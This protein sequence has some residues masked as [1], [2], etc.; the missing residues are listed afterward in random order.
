[1][2]LLYKLYYM[3]YYLYKKTRSTLVE[4]QWNT[5]TPHA[6][7]RGETLASRKILPRR[8]PSHL[9]LLSRFTARVGRLMVA[10]QQVKGKHNNKYIYVGFKPN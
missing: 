10:T 1:M 6:I 7:D 4:Q 2:P 9:H 5:P 3:E 8:S